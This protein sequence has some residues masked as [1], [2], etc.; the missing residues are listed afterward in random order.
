MVTIGSSSSPSNMGEETVVEDVVHVSSDDEEDTTKWLAVLLQTKLWRPCKDHWEEHR[1]EMSMLC[2]YCC[3][4]VC[5]HCT[6]DEPGHR[7]LKVRR[8]AYRSI[9]LVKDMHD[10]DLDIDVRRIQE[11]TDISHGDFSETEADR[12]RRQQIQATVEPSAERTVCVVL[13]L[14]APQPYASPVEDQH[15]TDVA[16]AEQS[17]EQP[18]APP[19]PVADQH[20]LANGQVT[21]RRRPRKMAHPARAPFF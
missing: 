21:L 6:H 14:A 8:Y 16:E 4:V 7:L 12:K 18:E 13:A 15:G 20:Q 17:Y 2:L 1:G 19:A 9:I 3:E 5:P 10:L 11:N